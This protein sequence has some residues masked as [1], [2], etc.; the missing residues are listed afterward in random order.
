MSTTG[1][2]QL[3]M[4]F[5]IALN[6]ELSVASTSSSSESSPPSSISSSGPSCS[7]SVVA[8]TCSS[9]S[10]LK[11]ASFALPDN[12]SMKVAMVCL[13]SGHEL[14]SHTSKI[15]GMFHNSEILMV[16]YHLS[17]FSH[18]QKHVAA[19]IWSLFGHAFLIS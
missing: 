9:S 5:T 11:T 2:C 17:Q 6:R 13:H 4:L 14:I 8:S 18:S 16:A 15:V 3:Q 1:L 10:R 12:S 7:S 19:P